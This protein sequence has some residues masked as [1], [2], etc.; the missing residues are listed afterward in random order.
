MPFKPRA[1]QKMFY[2][3]HYI[4]STN[5]ELLNPVLE[6]PDLVP[7]IIF[8]SYGFFFLPDLLTKS[9][10]PAPAFARSK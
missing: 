10:R 7:H 8:N 4:F 6:T 9:L 5:T 1:F 2:N 3:P